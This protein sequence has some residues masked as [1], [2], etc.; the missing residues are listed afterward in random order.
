MIEDAGLRILLTQAQLVKQV[1][2]EVEDVICLDTDWGLTV[3]SDQNPAAGAVAEG[4]AAVIYTSGSTGR[5]KGVMS[6]HRSFVNR[7]HWMWK[8]YPFAADEICCQKTALS[9]VDCVSEVFGPLLSGVKLIIIPDAVL[10]DIPRFVR[11]LGEGSVTRIVLVPSLLRS[12]MH[13][14]IGLAGRLPRLKYWVTSGETMPMELF[15]GFREAL[16]QSI[17][18]NL[19][20]SSEVAADATWFDTSRTSGINSLPIGHPIANAQSYILDRNLNPV[21]I[22]IAGELYIGG[23]GLARGY[24]NGPELTAQRFVP[25]PFSD[26]PGARLYRTGDLARYGGDGNVEF[27]GRRDYQ[28]KIRGFRIELGEIETVLSQHPAVKECVVL[29]REDSGN[30]K[31]LVAYVVCSTTGESLND[32]RRF[33]QAKLPYYMV[34]GKFVRLDALPLTPNGKAD[35]RALP[36]PDQARPEMD[37][38]FVSPRTQFE[39]KIA[40]VWQEVLKVEQVGVHD[41]FFELGGHSLLIVQLVNRLQTILG[42]ELSMAD[43]FR[44]PTVR[45][46]A[47]SLRPSD[48]ET[49]VPEWVSTEP[50]EHAIKNHETRIR[51]DNQ[52]LVPVN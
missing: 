27:L 37:A 6:T 34:P 10:K 42:V 16:P 44:Y 9:F 51:E 35:R 17:L 22:G 50:G 38:R 48:G 40:A 11:A 30:D 28:V 19:Y 5:P 32:L 23:D 25:H 18:L 39:R 36:A 46:L 43:L 14:E 8:T 29:A 49:E 4:L 13:T 52:E 1:E 3:K 7:F 21:P 20:G 12:I 45:A 33:V 26:A 24:L 15:E 2:V 31:Q 47:K 41:N